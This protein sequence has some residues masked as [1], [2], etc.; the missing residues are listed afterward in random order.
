MRTHV[1]AYFV[2]LLL[3]DAISGELTACSIAD[4]VLFYLAMGSLMSGAWVSH[5]GLH[6]NALCTAQG[7]LKNTG[8]VGSALW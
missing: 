6:L 7:A 3:C 8:N 4:V 5:G 1:V 2:S